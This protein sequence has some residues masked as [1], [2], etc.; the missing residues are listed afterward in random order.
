MSCLLL[1]KEL[2]QDVAAKSRIIS[3]SPKPAIWAQPRGD[4]LPLF[5]AASTEVAQAELKD[6]LPGCFTHSITELTPAVSWELSQGC[7]QGPSDPSPCRPPHSCLGFLTAW[8]LGF[9]SEHDLAL[10]V[11]WH[12]FSHSHSLSRLQWREH[13][14]H[15]SGK[16]PKVNYKKCMWNGSCCC[17]RLGK[18]QPRTVTVITNVHR[19]LTQ[20]WKHHTHGVLLPPGNLRRITPGFTEDQAGKV[21]HL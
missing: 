1:H 7:G 15:L 19:T 5:H 16:R 13:S 3:F 14:R 8:R 2:S 9:N 11:T 6:P 18:L 4:S 10:E 21:T 17:S 20:L 12:H